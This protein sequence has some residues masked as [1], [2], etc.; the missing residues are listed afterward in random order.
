[1][2]DAKD[3]STQPGGADPSA[4][5]A[6]LLLDCRG[7]LLQG[8]QPL[9]HVLFEKLDDALYDLADKAESERRCARYF[10]AMRQFRKH[11]CDI[12]QTFLRQLEYA[13][14]LTIGGL[15]EPDTSSFDNLS[16]E[17]FSL[18]QEVGLEES[19]AVGNLV[20]NSE[21]R[22][23]RQ[24]HDL[25]RLL[26]QLLG[27]RELSPRSNPLGPAAICDA[28]GAA[29][30]PIQE[31]DLSIKLVVYKLFDKHVMEHL[32]GIYDQC[33]VIAEHRGLAVAPR[34]RRIRPRRLAGPPA[35]HEGGAPPKLVDFQAARDAINM[36]LGRISF[37]ELSA[38]LD[39]WRSQRRIVSGSSTGQG[40]PVETTEVVTA[41][42]KLQVSPGVGWQGAMT[43]QDV[44]YR[45]EE[46]I[47]AGSRAQGGGRRRLGDSD[48]ATLD[49]VFLLF[50]S[51]VQ[52]GALPDAIKTLL[53]RLQ[54][55]FVKVA[56]LDRTFFQDGEHPAR[57]L[58]NRIAEAT[59]G[60]TDDEERG[61]NSLYGRIDQTVARVVAEFD[62]D[63]GLI[64]RLDADLAAFLAQEAQRVAAAEIKVCTGAARRERMEYARRQAKAAINERLRHAT[65]VPDVVESLLTQGWREVLA[66]AYLAGGE[67]G[68]EWR[69]AM[70]VVDRLIWSIQPK[71]G[72]DDR[73]ELLRSVPDLLRTLRTG[74]TPTAIDQRLVAGWFKDLQ[75]L[76]MGA[77]RGA[78]RPH[79]KQVAV[80]VRATQSRTRLRRQ[81]TEGESVTDMQR[82]VLGAWVELVRD[83]ARRLRVKLVWVSGDGQ[84]MQFVDRQGRE[85][86]EMARDNLATLI[87]YGLAS[88]IY[89]QD[90]LPLLDRAISTLARTLG[91]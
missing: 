79:S 59:V 41:L 67:A 83:D 34:P 6:G 4:L 47:R 44:R 61:P 3:R 73:R 33:L 17:D 54:I 75:V 36:A 63:L 80:D 15:I 88:V 57:R 27:R 70:A 71:V 14:E 18:T 29:L 5:L 43:S 48:E 74:L 90:D 39:Q 35:S 81:V 89:S 66:T 82:L 23:F 86:P 65:P 20:S 78:P 72:D 19:L 40:V 77:L 85:G 56:L 1:V 10:D 76:H 51:I 2:K 58:L 26:G 25:G 68:P 91:H 13:S 8:L 32:S 60:W 21:S 28:F 30:K 16:L 53:E 37:D 22:Y 49:L 52:V 46:S 50:E 45:I 87:E 84:R 69:A 9:L 38:L 31:L 62:R 42:T 64:D 12:K 11:G 55:P 24:L 7:A